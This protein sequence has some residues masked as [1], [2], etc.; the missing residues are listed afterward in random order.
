MGARMVELDTRLSQDGVPMV[1]HDATVR[2]ISGG[3]R[4]KVAE[5]TARR[6]SSVG[7]GAGLHIPTLGEV[8]AELTPSIPVNIELKY[9]KP[10]YR[11][12]VTAVCALIREL[13]V[14]SRILISS[15]HH[16]ALR[17]VERLLPEVSVAPLMG[18]LT[19]P[20]HEDDLAP[21]FAR[22]RRTDAPRHFPFAGPGAVV[23]NAMIDG[24][25]ASRFGG[26][27]ATLLTYTVDEPEEMNRLIDLGIDGIITNR[28]DVLESVL[29][30]RFGNLRF[31]D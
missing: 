19:G 10:E 3:K 5:M 6:L 16:A 13:D 2:R 24:E 17:I 4:G 26:Q 21:V 8:L 9:D 28:P 31:P 7:L 27:G 14:T 15:F 11:P 25:L 20:P 1:I 23:W 30:Q 12:L 29:T 22:A 18:C